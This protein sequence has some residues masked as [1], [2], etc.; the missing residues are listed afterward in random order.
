MIPAQ[1][2][3]SFEQAPPISVP[4]RFFL[5]APLF[6]LAAAGL[7][8]WF[9]P[10]VLIMRQVPAT[11]ALTHLLTIGV[12]AMT[13]CGALMQML[14]VIA[15]SPI[16]FPRLT[17]ALCHTLLT[18]GTPL[19]AAA[20]LTGSHALT[21]TATAALGTGFG[22][23]ILAAGWS[24]AK[25]GTC[26]STVLAMMLAAVSLAVAIPLG[27][28]LLLARIG[29][30]DLPYIAVAE[31]HPL[32]GSIGWTALLVV[33]V[34]YQV[35]P[36]F[37][38]T[39]DYPARLTR[40]LA[41]AVFL[42]LAAKTV[43]VL[44][45]ASPLLHV[46]ADIGLAAGLVAFALATLHLQ[47]VRKRRNPD[48]TQ[49]YWRLAMSMLILS[50]IGG[51]L[52]YWLPPD[53]QETARLLLGMLFIAGFALGVISGMLYKI[54]PFLAWF[55]LQSRYLRRLAIPNMKMLIPDADAMRQMHLWLLALSALVLAALWPQVFVYPAAA[56]LAVAAV[57][58]EWNLL[59]A[60][61]RYRATVR[62]AQEKKI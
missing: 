46:L 4:F 14:P 52:L 48:P 31:L 2:G 25:V 6:L 15:G 5:T 37:L 21:L 19:L 17:A 43:V 16:V 53:M 45:D 20:F 49:L 7:L 32:W 57:W 12:M 54:V 36:M 56:L 26:N 41:P 42:L 51:M 60:V 9:G 28:L 11:L 40:I 8:A 59:A 50:G 23:F 34:A 47:S 24:L 3:L 27:M 30:L 13:M 61:R 18:L 44:F 35:V 33:G 55:H 22:V 29:S 39:P 10:A 1:N 38:M 62:L 58:L